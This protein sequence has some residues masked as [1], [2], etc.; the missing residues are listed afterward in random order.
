MVTFAL[1]ERVKAASAHSGEALADDVV[2]SSVSGK[3]SGACGVHVACV[4][5]TE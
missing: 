2:L 4:A 1:V 5:I 3:L